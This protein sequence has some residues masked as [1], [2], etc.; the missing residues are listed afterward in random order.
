ML[1]TFLGKLPSV[2]EENLLDTLKVPVAGVAKEP[3]LW[4]A[5]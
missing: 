3:S 5:W 4:Q 1:L 2:M